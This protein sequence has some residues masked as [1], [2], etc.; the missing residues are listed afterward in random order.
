M[1]LY[2]EVARRSFRRSATYR[3]ALLAGLLTNAFFG[4][5]RSF[6]YIA[7][8]QSG[9]AVAGFSLSE[10]ISYTWVTQMLISIGAGWVSWDIMTSIR[11]GEVITE[12]SR[13]WNFYGYW[14]SR[15][16]GAH[17]FNLLVRGSLTYLLGAL[18]FGAH[19]PA[20]GDLLAFA[21]A[22][23]LAMLVSFAYSFLVNISAFWLIDS[24]GL[25]LIANILLG[26]FSGM[27]LPIS[28]FPEPLATLAR[29]LPFQAIT[30]L[31]AE[32]FLG[33]IG[34]ADLLATLLLQLLWAVVMT[35]LGLLGLQ[36]AVR[37][38][39]IQGG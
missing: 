18:Y 6:V 35:G 23:S 7:I 26:F 8:Y 15:T 39:V 12:L 25:V 27:L 19:V 5:V 2:F 37:K 31:P 28:F 9:G 36:A 13:P 34:G 16:L 38:V 17:S 30:G 29:A 4:A 11:S 21:A 20:P 10:A 14:L 33:K 3:T 24:T 1:R 32:V 22:V